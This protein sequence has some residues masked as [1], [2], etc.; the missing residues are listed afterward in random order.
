ML[1][2]IPKFLASVISTPDVAAVVLKRVL[3]FDWLEGV[4]IGAAKWIFLLLFVAIGVLVL[5]IPGDYVFEGVPHRRWYRDLRL[6]GIGVL[7]F[8]FVTYYVF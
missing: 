2:V 7:A 5:R 3:N 1:Q 8:I 4:P 6:W